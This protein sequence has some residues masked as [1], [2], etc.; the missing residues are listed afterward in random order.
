MMNYKK[1]L[2]KA[3]CD[4]LFFEENIIIIR[5]INQNDDLLMFDL[6]T[7]HPVWIFNNINERIEFQ[8]SNEDY[9]LYFGKMAS[10]FLDKKN[11]KLVKSENR[12]YF[13]SKKEFKIYIEL[14][15]TN[16]LNIE[17][18]NSKF[19]IDQIKSTKIFLENSIIQN[20]YSTKE[21]YA[22]D[23]ETNTKKWQINF[24][25]LLGSDKA[26]LNSDIVEN[27][28]KLYFFLTGTERQRTFCVD[29]E[30]GKVLYEYYELI[31]FSKI[32]NN[33][34]YNLSTG[35]LVNI[36]DISSNIITS[37]DIE[38]LLQQEGFVRA[39]HY[40]WTV[41]KG[42]IYFTQSLGSHNAKAGI[43]DPTKRE[44]I[45][46]HDF[47]KKHG[48]IGGIDASDNRIYVHTQ[49]NTLHVFEREE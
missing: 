41:H 29:A 3:E 30:T 4:F 47:D 8:N 24:N 32:E 20:P 9:Y 16:R 15:S 28:G 27:D 45:W 23:Y 6:I 5:L 2:T 25:K 21:L 18:K 43:L 46:K 12:F 17:R 31:S 19:V 11:G 10:D 39:D 37:W 36:L 22:I 13:I 40:R 7:N 42:L 33:V 1:I 14:N 44:L 38:D 49:D 48:A 26:S 34:L 35:Q